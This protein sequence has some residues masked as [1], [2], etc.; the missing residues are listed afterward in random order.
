M[1]NQSKRTTLLLLRCVILFIKSFDIFLTLELHI[2]RVQNLKEEDK[3]AGLSHWR[4]QQSPRVGRGGGEVLQLPGQPLPHEAVELQVRAQ[5]LPEQ[6]QRQGG[7]PR[8]AGEG[9]IL[10]LDTHALSY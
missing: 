1:Y 3:Y 9:V 8:H 7:Q 5:P 6:P 2:L 4:G 10:L